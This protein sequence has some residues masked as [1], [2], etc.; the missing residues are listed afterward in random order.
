MALVVFAAGTGA[1]KQ[2]NPVVTPAMTAKPASRLHRWLQIG[3][4]SWYGSELK[5]HKTA[6]GETY[7]P[8]ALTCAHR[9][10]PLGSWIKVTNLL[11]RR[12]LFLRVNDRGPFTDE[13]IIDVS[14]T[15]AHKLGFLGLAKVRIEQA[16]ALE[17]AGV[18]RTREV[19]SEVLLPAKPWVAKR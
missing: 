4:A 18:S 6:N 5:G 12:T 14:A 19:I 13:R 7:D 3:R 15:A 2:T 11:N 16:S 9:T 1:A 10:L 17:A 8:L